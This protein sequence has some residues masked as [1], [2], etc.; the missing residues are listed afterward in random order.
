MIPASLF[1]HKMNVL[2]ED[3]KSIDT[4]CRLLLHVTFAN[5]ARSGSKLFDTLIVFLKELFEKKIIKKK[6][7]SR[8]QKILH[9]YPAM[10]LKRLNSDIY[11][12][13]LREWHLYL[14]A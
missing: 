8:Q 10:A 4:F 6:P 14:S 7:S 2:V 3:V 5:R 13:L 12:E 1:A 9:D 11:K